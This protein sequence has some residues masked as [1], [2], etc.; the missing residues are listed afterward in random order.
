MKKWVLSVF[1]AVFFL[2]GCHKSEDLSSL[3]DV[4]NVPTLKIYAYKSDADL[5]DADLVV[6]KINDYIEPLIHANIDITFVP[7]GSYVSQINRILGSNE[8]LDLFITVDGSEIRQLY[9]NGDLASLNTLLEDYAPDIFDV[10]GK[11]YLQGGFDPK[12]QEY[13]GITTC[14]DYSSR[15]GL[16]YRKDIA[17]QYGIDMSS[18]HELSDLTEVFA[19]L[20]QQ[21]PSLYPIA[22]LSYYKNWDS[23]GDHLGV[24]LYD[25]M[26]TTVV[27]LYETP[28][29]RE[30]VSLIREWYLNGYLYDT[31]TDPGSNA[32]YLRSDHVFSC[33]AN[34][35]PGFVAQEERYLNRSIGFAALENDYISTDSISSWMWAIPKNSNYQKEA[36][37]FLNLLYTDETVINLWIYGI[38]GIHYEMIDREKNI[39]GFPDGIDFTNSGY[40]LFMGF[41]CGNQYLSHIW[42]GEPENVWQ[43]IRDF[44]DQA[45]RSKAFGFQYDDHNV[46]TE[47]IACRTVVDKYEEGFLH[48]I[49]DIDTVLPQFI[50]ELKLAGIDRIVEEKQTQLDRWL[51]SKGE[52]L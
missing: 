7:Y 41:A 18:V 48:G 45:I 47:V 9:E 11:E 1:L 35:K 22:S 19:K 42:E 6:E 29:Y 40:P 30:Y 25:R 12:T 36:M 24:L 38:E 31:V 39:A 10:V 33:F 4:S 46:K 44:N 52:S 37:Q 21:N 2:T 13:Y 49:Y 28:E 5:P 15:T 14:H 23:L 50:Q 51:E 3:P 17:R 26:D 34:G 8:Q 16:E 20:K 43:E 32:Y 27:N